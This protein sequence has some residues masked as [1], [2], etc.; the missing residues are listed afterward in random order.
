MRLPKG[1]G[2]LRM[3]IDPNLLAAQE[4]ARAAWVQVWIALAQ[5][6]LTVLALAIAIGIPI[7]QERRASIKLARDRF[8]EA[9]ELAN[10][11]LP[12]VHDW[13][14]HVAQLA[15]HAR[16]R[17]TSEVYFRFE[18]AFR[19]PAI[20]AAHVGRLHILGEPALPLQDA[21]HL[22]SSS[23]RMWGEYEDAARGDVLGGLAELAIQRGHN[24]VYRMKALLLVASKTLGSFFDGTPE[25]CLAAVSSA[26]WRYETEVEAYMRN[27]HLGEAETRSAQ[28]APDD[29]SPG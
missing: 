9:R 29:Q 13:A 4:Q 6:L 28:A 27:D 17:R 12:A 16:S 26:S 2:Y 11:I 14:V 23:Q 24:N 22:A 5:G 10:I 18:E 8:I 25:E 7:W 19:I 1:I 20:I 15:Q 21:M 3:A